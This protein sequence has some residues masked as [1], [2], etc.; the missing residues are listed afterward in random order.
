MGFTLLYYG[1]KTEAGLENEIES[2]TEFIFVIY[3]SE[4]VGNQLA[5]CHERA[6]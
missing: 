1:E 6:S 3:L 4:Y 5:C 2:K